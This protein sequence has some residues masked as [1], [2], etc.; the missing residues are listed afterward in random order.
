[1]AAFA[2]DPHSCQSNRG[3]FAW[4][5]DGLANR[6]YREC[7]TMGKEVVEVAGDGGNC[8]PPGAETGRYR[9]LTIG[10]L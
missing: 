1:M 10:L 8:G 6:P 5:P 3:Y 7:N 4:R 2:P 9:A